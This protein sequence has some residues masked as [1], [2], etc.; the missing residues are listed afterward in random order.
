MGYP[1]SIVKKGHRGEDSRPRAYFAR[2]PGGNLDN[3]MKGKARGQAVRGVV[4]RDVVGEDEQGDGRE[5]GHGGDGTLPAR[6]ILR[7]DQSRC[8]SAPPASTSVS[9]S[10]SLA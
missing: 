10:S 2:P 9:R 1:E 6:E 4:G 7:L 5:R 3:G 8:T